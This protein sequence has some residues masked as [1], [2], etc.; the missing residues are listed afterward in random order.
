MGIEG[1][2]KINRKEYG[3]NFGA[4]LANGGAV[5]ADE[6]TIEISAEATKRK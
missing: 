1:T 6:V 3:L 4:K 2:F 5:V